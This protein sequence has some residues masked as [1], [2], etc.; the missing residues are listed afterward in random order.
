[1]TKIRYLSLFSGIE[2]F[3]CAVKDMPEYTP[4]AF[5]E[6]E[7]FPCAV[8]AHHYPS[9]K[10]LGDVTKIDGRK[11]RGSVD[12][13]V[14]GSPCQG[15]SVA[16][17]R[18]GLEDPRSNLAFS[19]VRLV[20]EV[21]PKWILWENVPGCRSTNGGNDY[22]S[23]L[24]ALDGLNYSLAGTI[25]NS[26]HFGVAQR[27]RRVFVVGRLGADWHS[28]AKVLLDPKSMCGDP[29]PRQKKRQDDTACLEGRA[30]IGG[31][32]IAQNETFATLCASGAGC[33]RPSAQGS[34]L[35]YLVMDK[36]KTSYGI[37]MI[38]RDGT[39]GWME[40]K[41]YCLKESDQS[42]HLPAVAFVSKEDAGD[43]K[44]VVRRI[45]PLEAE[46]LQG[47]PDGWTDVEFKG[48]PAPDTARYKALGNSMTVNV[49]EWIANRILMVER[50]EL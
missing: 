9:V 16:G 3:S 42:G 14:G 2:A 27:R 23:F 11:L 8:L 44:Y 39:H 21:R 49:M 38:L 33:D 13:I 40:E 6:I 50:G 34:Q 24:S 17:Y 25:L 26:Q 7:P 47:F 5:A 12:I 46:R 4:V 37:R 15:F 43:V 32:R 28:P 1:M 30:G 22:R 29:P 45:T 48:K 36:P 41:A 20:E 31:E 10:N 35:D 19:Y 18:K